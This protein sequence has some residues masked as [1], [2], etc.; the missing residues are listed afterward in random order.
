MEYGLLK[1]YHI[2]YILLKK[3]D[4]I[5][6]ELSAIVNSMCDINVQ[7]L[8]NSLLFP[9]SCLLIKEQDLETRR[10]MVIVKTT[11]VGSFLFLLIQL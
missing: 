7:D 8:F 2:F 9:I 5:L 6:E 11:V 10:D 4:K 3:E 1:I